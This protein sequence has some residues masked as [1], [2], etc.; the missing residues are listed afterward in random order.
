M[1][2]KGEMEMKKKVA[3]WMVE[4]V[5]ADNLGWTDVPATRL[6]W[7]AHDVTP[8]GSAHLNFFNR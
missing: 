3:A 8:A 7:I 4:V 6:E 1:K 2:E 5:D